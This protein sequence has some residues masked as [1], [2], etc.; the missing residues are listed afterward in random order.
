MTETP[1]PTLP[2]IVAD[3]PRPVR[4]LFAVLVVLALAAAGALVGIGASPAAAASAE[5]SELYAL[6]NQARAARGLG[7]LAYDG[8]ASN[9]ARTW[10][11]ELARSGSLRHNPNL[12]AQVDSQVTNQWTRVGENVGYAQS[13]PAV[14]SLYMASA[15]HAANIL[16]QYNRVGVGTARDGA[17]RVWTTL[18]F[19][20]GPAL[21]PPPPTVDPAVF[22]PFANAPSLVDQQYRDLLGRPADPSGLSIWS[23]QLLSGQQTPASLVTALLTSGESNALVAPVA[24][25]YEAYFLRLPDPGGLDYWVSYMRRGASL[26]QVSAAFAGSP[27]FVARYGALSPSGFVDLVYRNVLGRAPDLG[28]LTYWVGQLVNGFRDRGSVMLGFSESVER[29]Q[30][31]WA[32]TTVTLTY[33]G[34]LNRTPDAGGLAYW[35]GQLAAGRPLQP[36]VAGIW[37]SPEYQSRRF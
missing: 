5:E 6:T 32:R 21:A 14:Q 27:E 22:R 17:G 34:M 13:I 4:R 20:L 3:P 28:G 24:R 31:T 12:V 23:G 29:V 9:V 30:A 35:A 25:L 11:Q 1:A 33:L 26:A 7:P 8:A 10:A 16:G 2:D 15:P 37:A 18:V 19:I 36:L